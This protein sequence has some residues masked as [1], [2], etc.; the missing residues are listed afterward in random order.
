MMKDT[1]YLLFFLFTIQLSLQSPEVLKVTSTL[2]VITKFEWNKDSSQKGSEMPSDQTKKKTRRKNTTWLV[3]AGSKPRNWPQVLWL[4]AV[5]FLPASTA[6][7]LSFLFRSAP[8]PFS[9]CHTHSSGLQW[10]RSRRK[11]PFSYQ[12]SDGYLEIGC[13]DLV[14][15]RFKF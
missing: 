7:W 2:S 12:G 9:Y 11:M 5:I 13:F 1:T 6:S 4:R 14:P 10:T 15:S 8:S 3:P